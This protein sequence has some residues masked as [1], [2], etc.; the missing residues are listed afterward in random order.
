MG[1]LKGVGQRPALVLSKRK[2]LALRG[3]HFHSRV[4]LTEV[5]MDVDWAGSPYV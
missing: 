5:R 1:G 3:F 2:P 4:N